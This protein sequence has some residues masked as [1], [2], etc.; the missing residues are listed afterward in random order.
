MK[1][2]QS[3]S[4]WIIPIKSICFLDYAQTDIAIIR[5]EKTKLHLEKTAE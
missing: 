3:D 1:S 2:I 4:Q 5:D